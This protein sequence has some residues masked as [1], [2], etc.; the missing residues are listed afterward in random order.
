[1]SPAP[2]PIWTASK[3]IIGNVVPLALAS[4]FLV[5]GLKHFFQFGYS[6][7][8]G[9]W[10]AAFPVVGWL[11]TAVFG[12]PGNRG[13]KDEMS[14]RWHLEHAFDPTPKVFIGFAR[15]SFKGL[16]DAHEDVGFLVLHADRLEFFGSQLQY[17]LQKKDVREIR[18]RANPHTWLGLGRFVAVE[19]EVE[20]KPV[21]MLCEPR[22]ASTL[23]GNFRRSRPLKEQLFAWWKTADEAEP[24]AES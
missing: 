17:E 6:L 10:L 9:L 15:P 12:L 22:E 4:P 24:V 20:G 14:R 1:M 21:R 19:G 3:K 2:K 5:L 23:I 7:K 18:F 11:A 16:L 8:A 13:M